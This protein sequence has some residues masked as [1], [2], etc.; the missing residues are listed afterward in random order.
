MKLKNEL[1]IEKNG[2]MISYKAG[3]IVFEDFEKPNHF[4][5]ITNS[6][7]NFKIIK[8]EF[9][10]GSPAERATS[11]YPG[12]DGELACTHI[13]A[14]MPLNFEVS[15]IEDLLDSVR[16]Y[17][18][19]YGYEDIRE[20][21]TSEYVSIDNIYIKNKNGIYTMIVTATAYDVAEGDYVDTTDIDPES[22]SF[23]G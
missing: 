19:E 3:T 14:A 4:D 1:I 11:E 18:H 13:V 22:I 5:D 6:F 17:F 15:N 23:K 7:N 9:E 21:M 20:R 8:S 16:M 10:K 2:E 12:C